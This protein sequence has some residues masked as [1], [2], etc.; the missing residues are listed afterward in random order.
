MNGVISGRDVVI[1]ALQ[2]DQTR[3]G[4]QRGKK[5][6]SSASGSSSA[7]RKID[8]QSQRNHGNNQILISSSSNQS[9]APVHIRFSTPSPSLNA[10][11]DTSVQ[12]SCK[13]QFLQHH[14][15]SS[16]QD[17]YDILLYPLVNVTITSPRTVSSRSGSYCVI[18]DLLKPVG[19][20]SSTTTDQMNNLLDMSPTNQEIHLK[21]LIK[22]LATKPKLDVDLSGEPLDQSDIE[23][24]KETKLHCKSSAE[25]LDFAIS[26]KMCSIMWMRTQPQDYCFNNNKK[27][28]YWRLSSAIAISCVNP[29]QQSHT[30]HIQ[31]V[32]TS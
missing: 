8:H 9:T 27:P 3:V 23:D 13:S 21:S 26:V 22:P 11:W 25:A 32:I 6:Q 1:K 12:D 17:R 18:Q 16:I 20:P 10:P 4:Q 24:V 28:L 15:V 29:V 31:T 5:T 19:S 30:K 2:L 14:Y 7:L